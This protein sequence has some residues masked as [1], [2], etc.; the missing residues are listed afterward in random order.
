MF[1]NEELNELIKSY[2]P[3]KDEPITA[4]WHICPLRFEKCIEG[5]P[6]KNDGKCKLRKDIVYNEQV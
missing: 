2:R 4:A 3:T 6:M 1:T 5:C